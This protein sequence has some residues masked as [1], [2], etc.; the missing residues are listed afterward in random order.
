[1]EAVILNV[2]ILL[3]HLPAL[4]PCWQKIP[5]GQRDPVLLSVGFGTAAP[6]RQRNPA[7]QDPEGSTKPSDP[8]NWPA[9]HIRHSPAN[10]D[11]QLWPQT[12]Q[13]NS[14]Y[15]CF[16]ANSIKEYHFKKKTFL[17]KVWKLLFCW[18]QVRLPCL[19]FVSLVW[20]SSSW[21]K[22]NHWSSNYV[23]TRK[24][25]YNSAR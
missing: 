21:L 13:Q 1:M 22:P 20:L 19:D 23:Q 8:Q 5:G 25:P 12:K 7:A 6:I 4:S 9:G 3:F 17:S 11:C 14:T 16:E 24:K 2:W 18:R 10:T 15:Q